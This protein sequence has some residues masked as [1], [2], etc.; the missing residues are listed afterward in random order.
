MTHLFL[1]DQIYSP[2]QQENTFGEEV[3]I[4][5]RDSDEIWFTVL[6]TNNKGYVCYPSLFCEA[7]DINRK[8]IKK[9]KEQQAISKK[10]VETAHKFYNQIK[11]M[12]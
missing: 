2:D 11:T 4:T 10:A 8:L 3:E 12:K 1:D 9:I 7:N 5:K 6:S